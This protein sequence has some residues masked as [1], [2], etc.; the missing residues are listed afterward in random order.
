MPETRLSI[1]VLAEVMPT[2]HEGEH[3]VAREDVPV[4]GNGERVMRSQRRRVSYAV[5]E[6]RVTD[7]PMRLPS[8]NA[9]CPHVRDQIIPMNGCR[10]NVDHYLRVLRAKAELDVSVAMAL[11]VRAD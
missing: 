2:V 6:A 5:A 8:F 3:R 10:F 4:T 7:N 11:T 1:A 9:T